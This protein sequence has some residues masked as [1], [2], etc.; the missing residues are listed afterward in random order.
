MIAVLRIADK[1][2]EIDL[3]QPLDISIPM[4]SGPENPN[5]WYVGHPEFKPVVLDDWVGS[6]QEGAAVNFTSMQII[7]HA[8]GT[9][10]ETLGHITAEPANVNRAFHRYFYRASLISIK[11]ETKGGDQIIDLHLIQDHLKDPD[12]EAL[13]IRTLPNDT[14]KKARQYSHT[15]WP[16]LTKAAAAYLCRKGIQHLLIDTP[17]VDREEDGGKLEAHRAFW[18]MDG[19]PREHATITEFIYADE[20]ITDDHY[21]LEMQLAN[22]EADAVP[23]RPVLYR[24]KSIS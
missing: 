18:D 23:S 17:S 13:V 24:I 2:I 14:T 19:I 3:D 16:Y 12:V 4:Q 5:A 11:P 7:P 9:H 6:V 22:I 8:Q 10:T 1:Q 15:N 21:V 20:S